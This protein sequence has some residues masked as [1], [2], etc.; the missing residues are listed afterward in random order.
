MNHK[1]FKLNCQRSRA[2]AIKYAKTTQSIETK[3]GNKVMVFW[4]K[5]NVNG[6]IDPQV[7]E[8]AWI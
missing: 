3:N 2:K 4:H 6:S 5:R 8:K 1:Y 7:R